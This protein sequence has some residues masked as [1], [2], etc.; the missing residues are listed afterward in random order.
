MTKN[1]QEEALQK[2]IDLQSSEEG[3]VEIKNNKS[4]KQAQADF[5]ANSKG[6]KHCAV[7][8][9]ALFLFFKNQDKIPEEMLPYFYEFLDTRID[10]AKFFMNN[11]DKAVQNEVTRL[12]NLEVEF[13]D[14]SSD[15]NEIEVFDDEDYIDTE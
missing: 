3:V 10:E 7:R 6:A 15:N 12:E 11:F 2:I 9:L 13:I 14:E 1:D 4:G 8:M 5:R